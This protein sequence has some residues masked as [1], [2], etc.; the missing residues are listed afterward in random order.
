M[1]VVEHEKCE[2]IP[3]IHRIVIKNG[4][5]TTAKGPTSLTL[6]KISN[7]DQLH[8]VTSEGY[9]TMHQAN[10][11]PLQWYLK[12]LSNIIKLEKSERKLR[13]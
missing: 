4:N 5:S 9:D 3:N 10:Y 8:K 11:F 6:Y 12:I 2:D 1:F 13:M 7:F